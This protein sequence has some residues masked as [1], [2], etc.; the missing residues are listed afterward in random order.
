[1]MA[2]ARSD[3]AANRDRALESLARR[4]EDDGYDV[5][6]DVGMVRLAVVG[7]ADSE[8]RTPGTDAYY[9]REA[10]LSA[11]REARDA[12]PLRADEERTM[13]RL[14]AALDRARNEEY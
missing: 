6:R 12:R 9:A 1:M 4:I 10:S 8:A 7:L 13:A 3:Y 2:S 11:E 14:K 5:E